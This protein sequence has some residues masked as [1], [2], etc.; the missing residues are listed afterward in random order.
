LVVSAAL[1]ATLLS[2]CGYNDKTAAFMVP[3]THGDFD[4]AAEEATAIAAKAP[5]NDRVIFRLEQGATLRA[6]G[7][8]AESNTALDQADQMILDYDQTP[9]VQISRETLA[10]LTNLTTL[11]YRGY[12]YDRVMMNTY[13]A[14]NY[15]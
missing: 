6:A 1:C 3:Y 5:K 14:L 11:D 8:F 7:R 15:M 2:G 10:A 4:R 9:D 13:K 12:C